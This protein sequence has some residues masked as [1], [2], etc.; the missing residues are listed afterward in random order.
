MFVHTISLA[1]LLRILAKKCIK[2]LAGSVNISQTITYSSWMQCVNSY[3]DF[4]SIEILSE[5]NELE[6]FT[7]QIKFAHVY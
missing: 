5:K 6:N 7:Q 2:K 4:I 1:I 3:M